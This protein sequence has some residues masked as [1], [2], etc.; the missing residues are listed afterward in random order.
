[1]TNDEV[2]KLDNISEFQSGDGAKCLKKLK[3]ELRAQHKALSPDYIA[4]MLEDTT[5]ATDI[6]LVRFEEAF[7]SRLSNTAVVGE[8]DQNPEESLS[9]YSSRAIASLHE[10]GVKDQVPGIKLS[11]PESIAIVDTAVKMLVQKRRLIKEAEVQE[12]LKTL[13]LFDKQACTA[14]FSNLHSFGH[15]LN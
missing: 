7:K 9:E 8:V 6:D 10:F 3:H 1:M 15:S 12:R 13:D 14:G 2:I 5:K 11:V 4:R